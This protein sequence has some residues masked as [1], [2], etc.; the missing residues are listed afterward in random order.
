M[1]IQTT[2]EGWVF[3]D[4]DPMIVDLLRGLPACA[5]PDDDAARR[6]I[7]S[8]LTGGAD[9]K[10]DSEWREEV[11]PELHKLFKD[12]VDIVASDLATIQ[13]EEDVFTLNVSLK[14]ARA[15]IHTL[16][17]ARLALGARHGVTEDDTAGR[18][19]QSGAK[20]FAIMQIDFYGMLISLL[21]A[22]TD[23]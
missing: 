23:L 2:E 5:A 17:Q 4:M 22:R 14:N 19:R 11:E 15:W 21:L 10:A 8:S 13:E 18:R 1:E 12:S 16:N 20:A 7:F 9:A 6:R 3:A